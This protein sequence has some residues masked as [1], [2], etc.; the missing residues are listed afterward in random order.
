MV[1]EMKRFTLILILLTLCASTAFAAGPP[2]SPGLCVAPIPYNATTWDVQYA[3]CYAPAGA[4][5]DGVEGLSGWDFILEDGNGA[6]PTI[7]GY[8]K[9]DRTAE[10]L[11]VGDGAATK[12]FYD[13]TA[14]SNTFASKSLLFEDPI[15]CADG[16]VLGT[17]CGV[18]VDMRFGQRIRIPSGTVTLMPVTQGGGCV[19]CTTAAICSVDVNASDRFLFGG[20][21]A[22]DGKKLVSDGTIDAYICFYKDSADGWAAVDNPGEH[23]SAEL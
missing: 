7:D 13:H 11:Q 22:G 18:G 21:S 2:S 4:V 16:D 12:E 15:V 8:I 9:Y 3:N 23:W 17:N 10:R 20:A 19:F 5:R 6:A 1:I 14:N